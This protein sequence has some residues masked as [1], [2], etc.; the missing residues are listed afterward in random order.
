MAK[1]LKI[2]DGIAERIKKEYGDIMISAGTLSKNEGQVIPITLGIDIALNGGVPEGDIINLAAPSMA[3]KTTLALTIITN[4]QKMG[5]QCYYVDVESRLNSSLL[6][7]IPGLDIKKL[8]II[9]STQEKFLTAEDYLNIII[10]IFKESPGCLMV[11]DSVAA[12]CPETLGAVKMGESSKMGALPTLMYGFFRRIAPVISA[13][14]STLINISHLQANLS[15]YGGPVEVGG[16]ALTYFASVRLRANS[17]QEF[18]KDGKKEGRTTVFKII[19]SSLGPGGSEVTFPI[20]YGQGYDREK[21][22]FVLAEERGLIEKSGA[23]YKIP[24]L[25]EDKYQG[26]EN[27]VAMLKA[28]PEIANKLYAAIRQMEFGKK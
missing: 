15:G 4:A 23:W 25:S 20:R 12:L 5:K 7:T 19:K 13:F 9:S 18:P 8:Q 22:I 16:N 2:I 26:E 24:S 6:E 27:T 3:G 28:N 21:D 11:I 1:E 17:S 14:K 10:E